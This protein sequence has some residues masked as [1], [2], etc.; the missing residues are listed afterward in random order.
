MMRPPKSL[1]PSV[2]LPSVMIGMTFPDGVGRHADDARCPGPGRGW[3]SSATGDTR[4]DGHVQARR[5][6]ADEQSCRR[7]P[8]SALVTVNVVVLLPP[9]VVDARR[10]QSARSARSSRTGRMRC[11]RTGG[12]GW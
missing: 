3:A 8:G 9:V 11:S 1:L 12:T 10:G 4:R 2:E 6:V 7:S 5:Q